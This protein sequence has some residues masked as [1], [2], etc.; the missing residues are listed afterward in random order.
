MLPFGKPKQRLY[1]LKNIYLQYCGAFVAAAA[2]QHPAVL[3][4]I[5]GVK[6]GC[7]TEKAR[8]LGGA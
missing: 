4:R 6:D 2:R 1:F 3:G 5:S 7:Y 8:S